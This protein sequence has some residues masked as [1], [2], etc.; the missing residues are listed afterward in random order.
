MIEDVAKQ[1]IVDDGKLLID[2]NKS[3]STCEQEKL[4]VQS[5]SKDEE[6]IKTIK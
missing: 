1:S 4:T 5:N 6:M 2:Y 3:I